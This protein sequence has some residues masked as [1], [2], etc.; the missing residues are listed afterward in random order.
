[1]NK[2]EMPTQS[3]IYMCI[4]TIHINYTYSHTYIHI[5]KTGKQ[6]LF[7]LR[8]IIIRIYF[9]REKSGLVFMT[10]NQGAHWC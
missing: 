10:V 4:H 8:N 6:K 5:H 3:L 1:M 2:L 7:D 9:C